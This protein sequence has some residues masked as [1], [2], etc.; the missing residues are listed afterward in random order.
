M[1][2]LELQESLQDCKSEERSI[3][4]SCGML[5]QSAH[6]TDLGFRK[7][8]TTALLPRST[9]EVTEVMRD[10]RRSADLP[11]HRSNCQTMRSA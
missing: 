8:I 1:D 9:P 6:E 4:E 5:V 11:S 3:M 10:V 7:V 2:H